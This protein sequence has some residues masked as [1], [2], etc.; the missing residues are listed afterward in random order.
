MTEFTVTLYSLLEA[1]TPAKNRE[2]HL[3]LGNVI[4]VRI[5]EAGN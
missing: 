4:S 1:N 5:S 2:V 3:R